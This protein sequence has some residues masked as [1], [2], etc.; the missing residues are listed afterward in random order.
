VRIPW[1]RRLLSQSSEQ[2]ESAVVLIRA[3]ERI[4][5][6]SEILQTVAT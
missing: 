2:I 5:I 3:L 4:D 6:L 1:Q